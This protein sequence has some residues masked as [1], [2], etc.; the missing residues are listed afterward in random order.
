MLTGLTVQT[1]IVTSPKQINDPDYAL[2]RGLDEEGSS[3]GWTACS[4]LI[5]QE[6]QETQH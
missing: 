3:A 4:S 5:L 6:L 1:N 2:K